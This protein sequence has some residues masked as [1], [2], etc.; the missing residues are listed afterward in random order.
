MPPLTHRRRFARVLS[1]QEVDRLPVVEWAP[2]WNQTIRRWRGEGL[3]GHLEDPVDIQRH[4]GL[5]PIRQI[6][7]GA[8]GPRTPRPPRHGAGIVA[9]ADDYQRIR[10]TLYGR[11][12]DAAAV[13]RWSAEQQRG[14]LVLWLTFNGFF[15]HPRTLLGIQRHLYAFYD[16]GELL[17]RMNADLLAHMQR[18]LTELLGVCTP[19]FMTFAEDMSY[20]HGPMISREMF[21]RFEAPYYRRIIPVL[22]D[23]GVRVFV[24]SDGDVTGLVD[25]FVDLGAEGFLPLERMAG[26]DVGALR[27]RRPRLLMIGAYDKTVMHRGDRAVRREFDRLMPVM[28]SGGFVAS[29][30][31]QTPPEVSLAQ[32]RR[33]LE[34][35]RRYAERAAQAAHAT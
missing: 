31:H 32:Y 17:H 15:W 35:Y 28:R 5:D 9:D 34:I 2:W 7:V 19:D 12:F 13:R 30:D 10:P 29:V 18:V 27:R 26:V 8:H 14:E 20:N 11:S 23:A 6:W 25:W 4:L 24:D 22:R 1:F 16:Q 21:D 3:P 33:Y